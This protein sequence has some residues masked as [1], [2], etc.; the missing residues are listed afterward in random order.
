MKQ[1]LL[2]ILFALCCATLYADDVIVLQNS[3]QIRGKIIEIKDDEIKFKQSDN[4]E[5]ATYVTA[6]SGVNK[7]IFDSGIVQYYNANSSQIQINNTTQNLTSNA[8]DNNAEKLPAQQGNKKW[9]FEPTN[10]RNI[11]F[12]IG[13]ST[14][15]AKEES[16]K[17]SFLGEVDNKLT[18]GVRFGFIA[19]PVLRY[20]I[21]LRTG[22]MF[23]FYSEKYIYLGE[24]LKSQDYVFSIPLQLSFQM[25]VAKNFSLLLYTGPVFDFELFE[26]GYINGQWV[27]FKPI[28]DSKYDGFN[29][30]WG[31][32]GGIQYKF[33]RLDIGG[34]FGLVNKDYEK[35]S[36]PIYVGLS[37]LF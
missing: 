24:H 4:P 22:L 16:E 17:Y 8:I 29:F 21:G 23:E 1:N 3:T 19:N 13:W 34:E 12:T 18:H 27:K 11:G 30:L 37:F 31:I 14:K 6:T 10:R 20:G 5:G 26:R 28:E 36:K 25:E 2:I 7:I 32:G 33:L 15:Q 9:R 35:W